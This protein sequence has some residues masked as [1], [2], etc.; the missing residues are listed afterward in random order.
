MA[1]FRIEVTA[2]AKTTYTVEVDAPTEAQA[3]SVAASREIFN[4]S[5]PEEFQ[6]DAKNCELEFYT[7]QLT[8]ECPECGESHSILHDDLPVCYC[9]QFGFNPYA[10]TAE[11]PD[12]RARPHPHIIVD[13]VC[14]PE[15]WWYDDQEYCSSC[16]AKIE[17]RE[18]AEAVHN[19]H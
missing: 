3:E 7:Q 15:P 14:T 8:A 19:A 18:A 5:I 10:G 1:I 2:I 12:G 17:A 6:V 16:G 4:A 13:G 11:N 9:G